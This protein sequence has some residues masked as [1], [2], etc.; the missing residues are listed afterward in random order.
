[1]TVVIVE[2]WYAAYMLLAETMD[3]SGPMA[4]RGRHRNGVG[5]EHRLV[6]MTATSVK[7]R[8]AR[9]NAIKAS[10]AIGIINSITVIAIALRIVRF[11]V[12]PGV[13]SISTCGLRHD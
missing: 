6:P 4:G 11:H 1:M 2:P 10:T 3:R 9:A 13:T 7:P 8:A 5:V 12:P